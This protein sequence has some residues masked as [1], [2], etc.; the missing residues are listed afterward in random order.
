MQISPRVCILTKE[1]LAEINKEMFD[2]GVQRGYV[3]AL[4]M[5]FP[6]LFDK[7]RFEMLEAIFPG[8]TEVVDSVSQSDEQIKLWKQQAENLAIANAAFD[9]ILLA[10]KKVVEESGK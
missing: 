6:Q 2:S 8:C 5:S 9:R 10:L 4:G 7:C 3:E 1:E